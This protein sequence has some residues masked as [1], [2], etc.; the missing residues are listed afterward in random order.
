MS[1]IFSSYISEIALDNFR[2]L[3]TPET[4]H[5][6]LFKLMNHIAITKTL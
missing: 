6:A 1:G 2:F 5:T 4:C 3:I